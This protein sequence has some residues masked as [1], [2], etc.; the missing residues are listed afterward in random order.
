MIHERVDRPGGPAMEQQEL[1]R[2]A[3]LVEMNRQKMARLEEQITKLS[4]IR[5]EQL[6][7]IAALKVLDTNQSTM[8]PLGGGVQLP[9]S[10]SGDTVVID[11]GSGIQAEKPRS[12]AI[13]ILESRL[14]EVE[15]VLTTLQNEFTQTETVVTELATTFTE[16]AKSIQEATEEEPTQADT[17][18]K[19]TR[20][21]RKHGTEFTLDD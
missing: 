3:Q 9:A 11:I 2:I 17:P 12:E 8:I 21:R 10:P 4:E 13:T 16:A 7:V 5:L 20:R 19:S 14:E 6:G 15:E 18:A 1:Q